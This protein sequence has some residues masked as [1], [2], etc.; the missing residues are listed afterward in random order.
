MTDRYAVIGKP[1]A[2][3]RSPELHAAFA[4]ATGQDLEY[5]RILAP[6][7]GFGPAVVAFRAAGGRGMLVERAAESFYVWRGVRPD[8]APV[9]AA[10][11]EPR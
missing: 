10:R 5:T 11:R 8:T 1:I 9:R 7:D 4:R 6:L 3:S 2:H